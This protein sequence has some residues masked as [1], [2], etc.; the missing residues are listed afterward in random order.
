MIPPKGKAIDPDH[1]HG[2]G[3]YVPAEEGGSKEGRNEKSEAQSLR[4]EVA[5]ALCW[6][7]CLFLHLAMVDQLSVNQSR[8]Q[9]RKP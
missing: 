5:Q 4:R 2:K 7:M 3:N 8:R 1:Q 6:I 9:E